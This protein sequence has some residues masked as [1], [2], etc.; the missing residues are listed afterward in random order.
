M[1]MRVLVMAGG[2]GGHVFPALAVAEELRGRGHE[3]HWLGSE[4]GIENRLVPASGY[5]LHRLRVLGVRRSGIA[6]LVTLPWMLLVAVCTAVRIVR[7][8]RPAITLGFGGFASGPGG[9]A[10]RLCGVPL[11]VHEQ[12]A[13]PGL[14][15]RLLARLARV[16]LEGFDGAFGGRG[17]AVGNPVRAEIAA[18]EPPRQRYEGRRGPLRIQILG[19]SQGARA[20]N[21]DLPVALAAVFGDRE[22]D[23]HHQ[24]G[25]GRCA[26]AE[27]AWRDAGRQV[28]ASEFIEDMAGAYG[29]ADLVICRAGALTVAEVAVAGVAA[30]FVPLPTA[31][32]DH[33]RLNAT[34]LAERGGARLLPQSELNEQGLAR[35]LEGLRRREDLA[36]M[37]T[38]A[39]E[40]AV[41]DSAA[42]VADVCEE[43][44]HG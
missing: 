28:T 31:V 12:N 24:A 34:W 16:V 22:L 38:R 35:A 26:E 7:R 44:A 33:Q 13:V 15:N 6:R 43:V 41:F 25:E 18:L 11:V 8:L 39:R 36:A 27:S 1:S 14:T 30:V 37:A 40:L 9:V 23:I 21:R 2:T 4:A 19:G 3:V 42:R 5:S 20:L 10:T 32:D 17:R 29:Q